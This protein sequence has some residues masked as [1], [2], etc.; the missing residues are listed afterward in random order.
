VDRSPSRLWEQLRRLR[1]FAELPAAA[2]SAF[3]KDAWNGLHEDP[4]PE[5]AFRAA[6]AWLAEAQ[7][8]S[9][10]NDGGVARHYSLIRGWGSSYPETTGY[11]VPTVL[12]AAAFLHD[13]GL[14]I[15]AGRMLDWLVSIQQPDGGFQGGTVDATPVVSVTF[16]TG[17]I[18]L[19]LA[20]GV[21]SF[22]E[23]FRP[24]LRRA[25]D[26][27]T[28]TQD[29]DGCW[30]KHPTPF[31]RKGEKAYETHVAWGLLEAERVESGRGYAEAAHK[32]LSWSLSRQRSN[33]WFDDCCLNDPARPLTHTI[34]YVLKGVLEGHR[35]FGDDRLLAAGKTTAGA[36]LAC[37]KPDGSLPGRLD[38]EWRAAVSWVCLTGVAQI[39]ACWFYLYT[40][41]GDSRYLVA[42]QQGTAFVRRTMVMS[43]PPE[44]R[45][46]IKGSYPVSGGYGSYEYLNWAPKFLADACLMELRA[47]GPSTRSTA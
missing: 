35:F 47:T 15:R 28:A 46:G 40:V 20:A 18:L 12:E 8:R 9:S 34:G 5:A 25:G 6:V 14:R 39:A 23:A 11:I 32:N 3:W 44:I 42:A 33:G 36:L 45:G 7:D 27:L 29:E 10:T 4:G 38:H 41:T 26:W 37:Q 13:D 16:N 24:A 21:A 1:D 19:G 31:A 43:G 22:D 30:R 2:R 17:Q